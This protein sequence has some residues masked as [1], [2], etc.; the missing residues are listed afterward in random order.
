MRTLLAPAF[1]VRFSVLTVCQRLWPR[2]TTACWS[3]IVT[4][5]PSLI[6]KRTRTAFAA[7]LV[8]TGACL[9]DV[10]GRMSSGPAA[11]A[12]APTPDGCDW[13]A[14]GGCGCPTGGRT[15]G[16]SKA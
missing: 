11:S 3:L 15:V 16:A 5:A 4:P 2:T 9:S 1:A 13:G 7:T 12:G 14:G 8:S 10:D 6:L